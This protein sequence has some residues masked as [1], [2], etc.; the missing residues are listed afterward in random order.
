MKFSFSKKSIV[1]SNDH[2]LTNSINK[3]IKNSRFE[4]LYELDCSVLNDLRIF[5]ST[6]KDTLEEK[7][8]LKIKQEE[9]ENNFKSIYSHEFI[10]RTLDKIN[11][12]NIPKIVAIQTRIDFS[13]KLDRMYLFDNHFKY[14][15]S[16]LIGINLKRG[17]TIDYLKLLNLIGIRKMSNKNGKLQVDNIFIHSDYDQAN[18]PYPIESYKTLFIF[19]YNNNVRLSKILHLFEYNI[20]SFISSD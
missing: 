10:N 12:I 6:D 1:K 2:L 17:R 4:N 8:K 16:K 13:N 15:V 3:I 7:E 11:Q 19:S 18:L 20:D 5:N 14:N 9:E